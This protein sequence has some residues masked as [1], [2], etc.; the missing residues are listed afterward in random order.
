MLYSQVRGVFF[1]LS[2]GIHYALP[3][4]CGTIHAGLPYVR[5]E[6]SL[7]GAILRLSGLMLDHV[8]QLLIESQY[9]TAIFDVFWPGTHDSYAEL[10]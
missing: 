1:G 7:T 4:A 8:S 9:S 3:C 6:T 5:G 2:N 10:K